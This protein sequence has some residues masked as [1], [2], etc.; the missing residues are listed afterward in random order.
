M[1]PIGEM[2]VAEQR[3]Y[4]RSHARRHEAISRNLIRAMAK[5]VE[6]AERIRR[7]HEQDPGPP[8]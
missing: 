5:A 6:K 3:D 2:T 7:G 8:L 1:K 4:W